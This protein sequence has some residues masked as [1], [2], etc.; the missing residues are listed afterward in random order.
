M[1][2]LFLIGRILLGG[3]FIM[4]GINHFKEKKMLMGYAKSKGAPASG[5][6][7]ISGGVLMVLGG[8]GIVVGSFIQIAI[9]LILI[10]MIPTTFMM[11][12]FWKETDSE[13]KMSEMVNFTKNMAIIGALLML[14][15]L[16]GPWVLSI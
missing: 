14:L 11:H 16:G 13:K 9:V 3:F 5:M 1:D 4:M 8:L 7:I 12:K 2:I 15:V 10:F 6:M